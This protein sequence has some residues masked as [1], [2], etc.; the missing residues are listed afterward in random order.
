MY[1]YARKEFSPHEKQALETAKGEAHERENGGAKAG[2]SGQ[3]YGRYRAQVRVS[4][5][6]WSA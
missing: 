2:G 5:L 1:T 6:G 4:R 3:A